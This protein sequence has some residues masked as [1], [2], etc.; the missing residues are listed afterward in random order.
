MSL[1]V[2]VCITTHN[3]REELS[4]TLAALSGLN[5]APDAILIAVDGCR[6]GTLEFLH[7]QYP[8]VRLLVHE[9]AMGSIPS[10]NELAAACGCDV[11][12]SLDDD[13]YPLE[14]DCIGRLR[15][16]FTMRPRLA[17][18]AFPQRSDEFP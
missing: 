10:R 17:V 1:T 18:A 4:R 12:L 11:F 3:R 16:L 14:A 7:S 6:D 9:Q 5:P 2:A 8:Q 15:E 13:S